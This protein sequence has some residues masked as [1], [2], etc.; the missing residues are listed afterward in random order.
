MLGREIGAG[1]RPVF[2]DERLAEP[3]R[4]P[5]ADQPSTYVGR[6]SG[7]KPDQHP[8]RPRWIGLRPR[9][10]RHGWQRGSARGQM[11][12]CAAGK[13]HGIHLPWNCVVRGMASAHRLLMGTAYDTAEGRGR[14]DVASWHIAAP[15]VC[16]GTSAVG[17]SRHRIPGASV[18]QPTEPCLAEGSVELPGNAGLGG[19][20]KY[21]AAVSAVQ[22]GLGSSVR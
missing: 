22:G 15:D 20:A 3:F 16:D 17:E 13:F 11:Q 4:Q 18:G 12:E 5:L 2:D 10:T 6:S 21:C 14:Y 9:D 1:P 8:H 7:R 19:G